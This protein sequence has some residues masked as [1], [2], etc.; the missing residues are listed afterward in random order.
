[1]YQFNAY[2]LQTNKLS[3]IA[4]KNICNERRESNNEIIILHKMFVSLLIT[5][6]KLIYFFSIFVQFYAK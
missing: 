4:L 3:I 1:M 2:S 5:V 6:Y